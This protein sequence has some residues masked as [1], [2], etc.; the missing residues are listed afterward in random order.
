VS[1]LSQLLE[2]LR[3]GR[4]PPGAAAGAVAVP[5]AGDELSGEVGFLLPQL[6]E[7][8]RQGEA[9]VAAARAEA[10]Q[11]EAAATEQRRRILDAGRAEAE[12]VAARVLA[13]RRSICE[14]RAR[15][16]LAEAQHEAE[17]VLAR[18][19]ERTPGLVEQVIQR[20]LKATT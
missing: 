12:R 8:E 3:R 17:R 2:R 11:L 20:L 10:S 19:R 18:G 6:D 14:N 7:I 4:P 1:A 13:E 15:T 16:I 9:I 5:S